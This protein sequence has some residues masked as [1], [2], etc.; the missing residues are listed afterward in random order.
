MSTRRAQS[1]APAAFEKIPKERS[2]CTAAI[3][4]SWKVFT[5]VL[6]HVML[7]TLVVAYCILGAYTFNYLEG[8]H[9]IEVSSI[10]IVY[11]NNTLPLKKT[12]R[13]NNIICGR[14]ICLLKLCVAT[15]IYDHHRRAA[16]DFN[17]L[18]FSC[19]YI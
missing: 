18:S 1:I 16:I 9:E 3:C 4:V 15:C 19:V 13:T 7:V 12:S 14:F 17:G 2:C 5:C 11:I 8:P 6:S 10:C